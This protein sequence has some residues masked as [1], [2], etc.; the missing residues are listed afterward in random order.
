MDNFSFIHPSSKIS[1]SADIGPFCFI[2]EDVEIGDNCILHSH[3]V[4]KG[5]TKISSGNIFYQF[6]Y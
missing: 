6:S 5:P 4:I 1:A 2:G 3:V